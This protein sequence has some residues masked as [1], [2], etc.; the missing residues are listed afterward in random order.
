MPTEGVG[1]SVFSANPGAL[2]D[3][4]GRGAPRGHETR[5]KQE[6]NLEAE[7]PRWYQVAGESHVMLKFLCSKVSETW[8]MVLSP[9]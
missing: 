3:G 1:E 8:A 2:A 7:F 5:G 4:G 9:H 6:T